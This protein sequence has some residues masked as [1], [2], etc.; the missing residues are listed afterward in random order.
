MLL[1]QALPAL[2]AGKKIALPGLDPIDMAGMS[3]LTPDQFTSVEWYIHENPL[4]DLEIAEAFRS[5]AAELE[6]D[7]EK[8]ETERT[9]KWEEERRKALAAGTPEADLPSKPRAARSSIAS[10]LRYAA[11]VVETRHLPASPQ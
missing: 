10:T 7:A 1:E 3:G 8:R 4:T 5:Q 2:R 9:M 11:S 6:A